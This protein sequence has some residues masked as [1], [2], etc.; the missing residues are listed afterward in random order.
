[1]GSTG[2]CTWEAEFSWFLCVPT[3]GMGTCQLVLQSFCSGLSALMWGPDA[4]S[5]SRWAMAYSLLLAAA[6]WDF[7]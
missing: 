6:I 4:V 7:R 2:L 3:P 5:R 1:M